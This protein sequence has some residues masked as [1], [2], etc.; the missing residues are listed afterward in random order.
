MRL[1]PGG[2]D[3]SVSAGSPT[4]RAGRWVGGAPAPI[5]SSPA[6]LKLLSD[7]WQQIAELGADRVG[8]PAAHMTAGVKNA[9]KRGHV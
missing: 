5:G 8:Q 3:P 7:L 9:M 1:I 4:D 2:S 6:V